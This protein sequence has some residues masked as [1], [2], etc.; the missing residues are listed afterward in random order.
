MFGVG[1]WVFEVL[2][3]TQVLDPKFSSFIVIEITQRLIGF[4]FH[5]FAKTPKRLKK[6]VD[7]MVDL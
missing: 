4:K 2:F 7:L 6:S 1:S 5:V 3:D